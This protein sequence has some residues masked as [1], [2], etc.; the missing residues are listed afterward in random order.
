[1]LVLSHDTAL[2][3][4]REIASMDEAPGNP[5][6]L[7][8]KPFARCFSDIAE[9]QPP[10]TEWHDQPV[11]VLVPAGGH[12]KGSPRHICHTWSTPIPAAAYHR[13]SADV[14]V[15][16]PEFTF[17]QMAASLSLVEL[18]ALGYELCGTY[19]LRPYPD[20]APFRIKPL[21]TCKNLRQFV[22]KSSGARGQRKAER[23]LRYI[24]D[25]SHSPY[26]TLTAMFLCTSVALGGYGLPLPAMNIPVP[27]TESAQTMAMRS[28]AVGDLVWLDGKLDIEYLGRLPHGSPEAMEDDNARR[29]AIEASDYRVITVSN[30]MLQSLSR[31]ESVATEAAKRL[32][33]RMRPEALGPLEIRNALRTQAIDW[34][35]RGGI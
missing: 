32:G 1:M 7:R 14:F 3:Y 6:R 28:E 15:C 19:S 33:K 25:G 18:I 24:A 4:W 5:V 9:L 17:L 8:K 27:L 23:A 35:R 34:T 21:T 11:D 10:W 2:L 26:E 22:E 20:E 29:N 13:I 30:A 16:S 12:H 31:F